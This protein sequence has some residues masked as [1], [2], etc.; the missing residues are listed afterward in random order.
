MRRRTEME[1]WI[2]AEE[3]APILHLTAYQIRA[4]MRHH[5]LDIGLFIPYPSGRKGGS[6]KI[7][8][9]KAHEKAKEWGFE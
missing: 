9:K 1:D 6:Y 5:E 3:A 2:S 4:A 8:R 7:S